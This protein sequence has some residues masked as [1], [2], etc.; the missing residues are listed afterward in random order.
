MNLIEDLKWRYATKKFDSSKTVSEDK[1]NRIKEAINLSA[2]S[3]GLQPFIVLDI[4][5]KE[6]REKLVQHTWGQ[7][8]VVDASHLFVFCAMTD[9]TDDYIQKCAENLKDRRTLED[10]H[11]DRTIVVADK[12]KNNKTTEQITSWASEQVHIAVGT[13]L[14]ACADER[15]DS[16]PIGGFVPEG[17]NEVLHLSDKSLKAVHVLPIG[18]RAD[19]DWNDKYPKGRKTINEL[20]LTI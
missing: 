4:R 19:D 2:S 9:L 11:R 17:Y 1:I 12:I 14:I 20:F 5:D 16:C 8:Q 3:V 13:A 10:K 15:V 18:Y 7:Q 6:I